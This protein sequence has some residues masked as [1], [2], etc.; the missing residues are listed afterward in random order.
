MKNVRIIKLANRSIAALAI[1]SVPFAA[2]PAAAQEPDLI[3][4]PKPVAPPAASQPSAKVLTAWR[5]KV[6]AHLNAHKR[7]VTNSP[8]GVSTV[9][10]SIDRS[11]RVLS[12]EILKSSG[13]AS[14][15]KEAVA[16]T[17]RSSPVPAPPSDLTGS[18]LYLKVPIAFAR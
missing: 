15:D 3:V 12:A 17:Q 16:L 2:I 13:S 6:L 1:L 9:A 5:N 18:K 7:D 8:G 14:L 10:F 11:G 4:S